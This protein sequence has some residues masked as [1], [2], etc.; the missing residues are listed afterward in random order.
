MV[1]KNFIKY[2]L[3]GLL[4]IFPLFCTVVI[5]KYVILFFDSMFPAPVPGAGFV[6]ALGLI[7]LVGFLGRQVFFA[8]I[9]KIFLQFIEKTPVVSLIYRST[10]DFTEAFIGNERKFEKPIL[11]DTSGSGTF[12]VGFLTTESFKVPG[13]E[14]HVGV[15]IP[16]SYNFS[17]NYYIVPKD[18]I[19][20]FPVSP[21]QAMKFAVTG[22]VTHL[23]D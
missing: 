15:Y 6:F 12:R 7:T 5:I 17:G 8:P 4:V 20:P 13:L 18:R 10:K 14:T 3:N 21:A 23:E 11:Y 9:V 16:H 1:M 19:R 2:F 22:G